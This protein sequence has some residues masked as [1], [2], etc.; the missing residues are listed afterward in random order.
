MAF[1]KTK[2]LE[3]G[4]CQKIELSILLKGLSSYCEE[5]SAWIMEEGM[6][7]NLDR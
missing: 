3:P 4:E 2:P 7:R 6:Y 5:K 1:A